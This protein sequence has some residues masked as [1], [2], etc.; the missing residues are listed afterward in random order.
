MCGRVFIAGTLLDE[1]YIIVVVLVFLLSFILVLLLLNQ[2]LLVEFAH[3]SCEVLAVV[4][5]FSKLPHYTLLGLYF[6][7]AVKNVFLD[8][9]LRHL[10]QSIIERIDGIVL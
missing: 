6:K 3:D 9:S 1:R 7:D 2:T 4:I 5:K 10:V 8:Q